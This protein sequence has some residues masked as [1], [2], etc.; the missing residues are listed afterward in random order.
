MKFCLCYFGLAPRSIRYTI[1]SIR[2]NVLNV[3]K[4][5]GIEYDIYMHSF[6]LDKINLTRSNEKDIELNNSDW[7]LLEPDFYK[8]S[9]R[10][11]LT[12]LRTMIF[13][14]NI[15]IPGE[16]VTKTQKT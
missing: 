6:L 10:K 1:D 9:L 15:L 12:K 14:K 5:N 7:K 11:S 13:S 8:E 16:H 2:E 4:E 3:L